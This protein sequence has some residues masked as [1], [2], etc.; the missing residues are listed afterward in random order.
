MVSGKLTALL[1]EIPTPLGLLLVFG[2]PS[3]ALGLALRGFQ[4]YLPINP[5]VS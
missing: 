2:V 4:V 3:L 5:F 1:N